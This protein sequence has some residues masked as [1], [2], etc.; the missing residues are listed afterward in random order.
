MEWRRRWTCW[1]LNDCRRRV[2]AGSRPA[3]SFVQESL[4][5]A[6]VEIFAHVDVAPTVHGDGMWNVER[7]AEE[8]LLPEARDHSKRL[9]IQDPH[10]MVRA[11]DH[12]QEPLLRIGR[13]GKA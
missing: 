7:A 13:Q 12:V 4:E 8:P 10:V 6:C 1:L 2:G 9:A 5:S 3:E 11:V